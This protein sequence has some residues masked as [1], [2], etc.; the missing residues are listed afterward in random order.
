MNAE[1]LIIFA[2]SA[3]SI[4]HHSPAIFPVAPS[5]REDPTLPPPNCS[6]KKRKFKE[7]LR[8]KSSCPQILPNLAN[9]PHI[10][11]F[12]AGNRYNSQPS[13]L[14]A[15]QPCSLPFFHPQWF[16]FSNLQSKINNQRSAHLILEK[17]NSNNKEEQILLPPIYVPFPLMSST[18]RASGHEKG[19]LLSL[20]L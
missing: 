17:V 3:S 18:Y 19:P 10:N 4:P 12:Q 14:P 9:A 5:N 15:F 7:Q 8:N 13:V 6:S 20:L 2:R 16:V 11:G 1:Q